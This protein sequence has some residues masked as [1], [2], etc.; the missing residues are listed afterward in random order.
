[1]VIIKCLFNIQLEY[2]NGKDVIKFKKVLK[3]SGIQIVQ[4]VYY[5]MIVSKLILLDTF[6]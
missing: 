5:G 2:G 3:F 6:F 1:M 4:D